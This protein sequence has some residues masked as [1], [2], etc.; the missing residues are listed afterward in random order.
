MNK[1]NLVIGME[2]HVELKTASKMFCGCKNDPFHAEKPNIYTC[3]VCLGLP[4]ALPF[5]NKKAIEWTIKLG[6]ALGC[7]INTLSK[8]DR[9]HYFYPDLP[10]GYQ[11]SQYD[12]PF[13]YGGMVE[14]SSGPI[15]ITRVHL[16]E[17]TG[18]LIHQKVN[19]RDVSLID[20]NRSSVPLIEIVTEPDI[21]SAAQ[22]KEYAKKLRQIIRYLDIS[23]CDMEK[24]GMRLEA[25]ISLQK[26][27]EKDL[28]NYKVELK[29]IN[30]FR[31]LERGIGYE[32][33]RQSEIL[34]KGETPVQETR[35]YNAEKDVTYSQRTKEEAADYRYFPDP[36]LPPIKIDSV[37]LDSIKAT[38]PEP[39]DAILGMWE[40]KYNVKPNLAELIFET[41]AEMQWLNRLFEKAD[42]EKIAVDKMVNLIIHKKLKA[43]LF[44]DEIKNIISAYKS[45][46]A[47][48]EVSDDG[49]NMIIDKILANN[50]TAVNDFKGGKNQT[51]N[52]L[53][54]QVMREA[55]KKIEFSRLVNL[56]KAS[57]G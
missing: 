6:L 27:G 56:I 8:F 48:D 35:G 17:D 24:G 3:P 32:E 54:G 19:G 53:V 1:R 12:L 55:K 57:I 23:D 15:R 13:C 21:K 30:S 46:I 28:P 22:A 18:K 51:M 42:N 26:N 4:G 36:D 50:P 39:L 7:K 52:F 29:N 20:F 2:V 9:K 25:N 44:V 16:E 31:F 11:I 49:L 41:Q 38:V 33:Q 37:W 34:E 40:K 47:V 45:E 43:N 14:T 10:K 5:A